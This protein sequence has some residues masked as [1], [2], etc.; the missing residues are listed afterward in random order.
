MLESVELLSTLKFSCCA[1]TE[2]ENLADAAV[3][4][5]AG[6]GAGRELVIYSKILISAT[7]GWQSERTSLKK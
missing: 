7:C 6:A 5:A 2:K 1:G 4:G 3:N